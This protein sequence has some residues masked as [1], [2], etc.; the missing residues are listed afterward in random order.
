VV[1]IELVAIIAL[2]MAGGVLFCFMKE[3]AS[4]S[5]DIKPR[6]AVMHRTTDEFRYTYRRPNEPA[7][8]AKFEQLHTL[9]N[10]QGLTTEVAARSETRI[11]VLTNFI[12]VF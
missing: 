9:S 8:I 1:Y 12:F 6:P 4:L 7:M 5:T 3:K 11:E 10:V 2:P